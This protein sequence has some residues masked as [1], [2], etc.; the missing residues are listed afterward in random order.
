MKISFKNALEQ[1]SS[2]LSIS[3]LLKPKETQ[4]VVVPAAPEQHSVEA[5]IVEPKKE[6]NGGPL[7]GLPK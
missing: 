4:H 2:E 5:S 3:G 1:R 6:L 7:I